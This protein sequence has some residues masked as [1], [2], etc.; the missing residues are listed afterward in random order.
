L[1]RNNMRERPYTILSTASIPLES[2][3]GIPASIDVR[4]IPFIEILPRPGEELIQEIEAIAREKKT[5]IFT[6]AHAVRAVGKWAGQ[7]PDWQIYCVGRET[8]TAIQ[9]TFG[10][11]LNIQIAA[12]A[13]SLSELIV[14]AGIKQAVFF[15]GDQRLDT[16]PVNLRNANIQ[17]DQLVVYE[18]RLTPVRLDFQPDVILFFSPTAVRSFFSMNPLQPGVK[19]FA[20][21]TT[22]EATLKQ[23]TENPVTI[24]PQADKNYV[25][26]MAIEHAG[27]H[28]I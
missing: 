15:C 19:L 5:V 2:F 28:P 20:M 23:F 11:S 10:E 6:S 26:K 3:P 27:L 8:A 13:Q 1:H 21:G 17:L 14:N 22:T 25:L 16:I 9:K 24:S 4:M 7:N 12:N 18:T